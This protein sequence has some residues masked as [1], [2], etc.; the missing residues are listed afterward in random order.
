MSTYCKKSWFNKVSTMNLKFPYLFTYFFIVVQR[1]QTSNAKEM[2][3]EI[4]VKISSEKKSLQHNIS[5]TKIS[6]FQIPSGSV[7]KF[8]LRAKIPSLKIFF[9]TWHK[10]H[11]LEICVYRIPAKNQSLKISRLGSFLECKSERKPKKS[12][13]SREQN[14]A[15]YEITPLKCSLL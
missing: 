5:P 1:L 11:S 9:E 15:F 2:W 4:C 7:L 12:P 10:I 13:K 3:D 6:S 14:K 8:S